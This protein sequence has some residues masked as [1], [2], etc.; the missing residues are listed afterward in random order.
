M[1]FFLAFSIRA[2]LRRAN[3][4]KQQEDWSLLSASIQN[5]I[6]RVSSPQKARSRFPLRTGSLSQPKRTAELPVS[7]Q[8]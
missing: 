7:R 8:I 3:A 6:L 4:D 1:S 2:E 5:R